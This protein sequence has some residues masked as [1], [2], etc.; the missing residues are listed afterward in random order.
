MKT[1]KST[2]ASTV[3]NE[4]TVTTATTQADRLLDFRQ[5]H[6]MVGSNCKT[7]HTARALAKRGLIREVRWNERVIRYSEQ[8][9]LALI[10]GR[11]ALHP[12]P[13]PVSGYIDPS[14]SPQTPSDDTRAALAASAA[15]VAEI[16]EGLA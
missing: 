16:T 13:G 15:R 4:A 1:T 12:T 3:K 7:G 14:P 6:A 9:V 2:A 10:A 8:S 5:V 11:A